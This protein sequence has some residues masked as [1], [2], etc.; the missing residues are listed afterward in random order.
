MILLLF[1]TKCETKIQKSKLEILIGR[2]P[3]DKNPLT[4]KKKER[5]N[6][7]LRICEKLVN[8]KDIQIS[9]L[10]EE[11]LETFFINV[12]KDEFTRIIIDYIVQKMNLHG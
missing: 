5:V 8:Y 7:L 12:V 6:L 2:F 3:F 4:S 1:H 11:K 9:V 10:E